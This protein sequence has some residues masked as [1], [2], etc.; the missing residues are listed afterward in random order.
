MT[1]LACVVV[2]CTVYAL[3][4]P[5]VTI[6][7]NVSTSNT[8]VNENTFVP[9][10]KN[11]YP[12]DAYNTFEGNPNVILLS[13]WLQKLN[14]LFPTHYVF[15]I[16]NFLFVNGTPDGQSFGRNSGTVGPQIQGFW[17]S[18]VASCKDSVLFDREFAAQT[19]NALRS[20]QFAEIYH[21]LTGEPYGGRQENYGI[22][23]TDW[24]A[25]PHQTWSATAYLRNVYMDLM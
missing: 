22:A 16:E 19:A 21:P 1:C 11:F 8:A 18:A 20:M 14:D 7:N 4:L 13:P 10:E 3:I 23:I 5:A 15:S 12:I 9:P 25:E 2:F 24:N 6:E 17:A